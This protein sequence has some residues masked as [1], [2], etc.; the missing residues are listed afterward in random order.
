MTLALLEVLKKIKLR[1]G[2]YLG[3]P[4]L[5]GL[6]HFIHGY[7]EREAETSDSYALL[8]GFEEFQQFVENMYGLAKGTKC[9][10]ALIGEDSK[11]DEVAF[12]KYFEILEMYFYSADLEEV[13]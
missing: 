1:P 7:F 3:K 12:F 10:F 2:L 8:S 13:S 4:T 11:N 5:V 6:K 9:Y